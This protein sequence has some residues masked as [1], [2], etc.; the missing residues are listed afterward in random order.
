M[1]SAIHLVPLDTTTKHHDHDHHQIVIG[2]DGHAEFEIEGLGGS[3]AP[4]SGCI[5]PASHVHYYEGVGDNRHL[6]LNLPPTSFPLA[7]AQQELSRLFDAPLFFSL[8]EALTRYLDF[9]VQELA[10]LQEGAPQPLMHQD[11]LA[12][13]FLSCLNVRMQPS[14]QH[15][16]G[17]KRIDLDALDRYIQ[18]HLSQ[19]LNVAHL[20]RQACLS[21]AHFNDCFRRQTGITPYQYLLTRRLRAAR[22]LL[23]STRLPLSEIADQ[24]GFSSQSALSHAFRRSFGHP[25]SALRRP[26]PPTILTSDG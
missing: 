18:R 11:M 21:E 3:I 4:L 1:P 15:S 10:R 20:A 6:I 2:V 26:T 8:D 9:L 16:S 19:R 12:S 22:H 17:L 7:G 25:P 24:T 13:T 23:L 5:V 14:R